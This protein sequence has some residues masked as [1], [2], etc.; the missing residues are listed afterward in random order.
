MAL[1]A[2]YVNNKLSDLSAQL[3]RITRIGEDIT[4]TT[5]TR[6]AL[7]DYAVAESRTTEPNIVDALALLQRKI[8]HLTAVE[9][10]ENAAADR[11]R[12]AITNNGGMLPAWAQP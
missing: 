8:D 7:N 3:T 9:T 4:E 10:A 6:T 5:A 2:D 1:I 11:L 12:D